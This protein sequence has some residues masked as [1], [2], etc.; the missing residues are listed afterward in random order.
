MCVGEHRVQGVVLCL[1]AVR[2]V[3]RLMMLEPFVGLGAGARAVLGLPGVVRKLRGDE[4]CCCV[5]T[6]SRILGSV[7]Q[8][9]YDNFIIF[10]QWHLSDAQ[11]FRVPTAATVVKWSASEYE[12]IF[13][14][15]GTRPQVRCTSCSGAY[16]IWRCRHF[17]RRIGDNSFVRSTNIGGM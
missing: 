4:T 15:L 5:S 11:V 14:S 17:S 6:T 13:L 9:T 8:R 7:H 1:R 10:S 12:F 3:E 2:D 16:H